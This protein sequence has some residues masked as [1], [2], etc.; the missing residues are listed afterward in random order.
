MRDKA[1]DLR[2]SLE[3]LAGS[4]RVNSWRSSGGHGD[5]MLSSSNRR[6]LKSLRAKDQSAQG[7][8]SER[9][10]TSELRQVPSC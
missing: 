2:G 6:A 1:V 7:L 5:V 8:M 3:K 4:E 10:S 9:V